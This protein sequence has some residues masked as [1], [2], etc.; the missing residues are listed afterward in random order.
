MPVKTITL[1]LV[2]VFYSITSY[3]DLITPSTEVVNIFSGRR[4]ILPMISVAI[5]VV[6]IMIVIYFMRKK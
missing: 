6:L 5:G 4:G 1:V 2:A 3:A